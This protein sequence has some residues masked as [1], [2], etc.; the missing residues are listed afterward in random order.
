MFR[1]IYQSLKSGFNQSRLKFLFKNSALAKLLAQDDAP[2]AWD[3][4]TT[5]LSSWWWNRW[6]FRSCIQS[7]N[8]IYKF[9]DIISSLQKLKE[10]EI[11]SEN[12]CNTVAAHARPDNLAD[13][14]ASLQQAR[15]LNQENFAAL[16]APIH[17]T[18][19]SDQARQWVCVKRQLRLP[20]DD[21]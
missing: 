3:F 12:N 11:F 14:L 9:D 2:S 19:L 1:D 5:Y 10:A 20:V 4:F 8:D 18:L 17:V 16:I 6:W 21:N 15:I 13:A 7:Q